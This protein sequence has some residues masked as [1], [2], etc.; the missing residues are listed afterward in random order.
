MSCDFGCLLIGVVNHEHVTGSGHFV[1]TDD[2]NRHGR[3]CF[4]Q[5][6]SSVVGHLTDSSKGGSDNNTVPGFQST[7]LNQQSSDRTASLI[8]LGFDNGAA[9]QGVG[10]GL[11]FLH[12]RYQ[13]NGI[14]QIADALS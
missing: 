14:Q 12:F 1:Q 11:E 13:Q 10:V 5:F 9:C 8:Q 2:L 3:L 4:F 7:L 6:H